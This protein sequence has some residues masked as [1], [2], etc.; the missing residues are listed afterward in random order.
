MSDFKLMNLTGEFIEEEDRNTQKII[1]KFGAY[2]TDDRLISNEIHKVFDPSSDQA[3]K[4]LFNGKYRLNNFNGL[5]RTKSLISTLLN[6]FPDNSS[7]KK[8]KY[9]PNE[10]VKLTGQYR[11]GLRVM[12]CPLFCTMTNN[13]QYLIDL[14]MQNYY[15]DGLDL[16]TLSIDNAL[17]KTSDIPVIILLLLFKDSD[18]NNSFEILPFKKYLNDGE[19]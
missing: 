13:K 1:F 6:K 18:F 11:E 10:N 14:E 9:R 8:Q 4:I 2:N 5:G 7:I 15:F 17:R 3:I 19:F 16:N 12:D